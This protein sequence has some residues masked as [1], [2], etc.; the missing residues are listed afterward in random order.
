[1]IVRGHLGAKEQGPLLEL[2][3]S[4]RNDDTRT[5]WSFFASRGGQTLQH[6]VQDLGVTI[7]ACVERRKKINNKNKSV[8]RANIA[9]SGV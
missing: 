3:L 8:G 1:L 9:S 4:S 6:A 2:L 5:Q 7:N